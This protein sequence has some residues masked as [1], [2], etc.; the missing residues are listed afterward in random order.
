MKLSLS[1]ESVCGKNEVI[2]ESL[3][4][5]QEYLRK[6]FNPDGSQL[7]N[8]Q[9]LMLDMLIWFDKLCREHDIRYWLSSGTLLGAV[10][11][12]GY[13]PWDD[14]VDIDMMREDYDKLLAVMRTLNDDTYELQDAETD[15]GYFFSYGKLRHKHSYLEETNRYDRIFDMRGIYIDLLTFERMPRCFNRIACM[16]VGHSYK[17]LNTPGIADA[18]AAKRVHRIRTFNRTF[19]FPVLRFF[20]RLVPSKWVHRSPGIPY[21][22]RTTY[23][24]IFPVSTVL[25][26]GHPFPAPRDT[27]SYLTRMFGDYMKLP[28]L[29]NIHLHT[30]KI[31][32]TDNNDR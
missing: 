25:F 14:D 7:R 9:L 21:K 3:E 12:G 27:H 32:M 24:E 31:T 16:S 23:D 20:A 5:M 13:I 17:I 28:D 18:D 15:S 10:R 4:Q 11:H 1:E 8:Q 2:A 29:D 22:S 19:L 6:R 30:L 26:E